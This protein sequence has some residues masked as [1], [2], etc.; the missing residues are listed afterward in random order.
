MAEIQQ[1]SGNIRY[2]H[3]DRYW[4]SIDNPDVSR[5]Y[6]NQLF[7]PHSRIELLKSSIARIVPLKKWKY[8]F[9]KTYQI[10]NSKEI[11]L[12]NIQTKNICNESQLFKMMNLD[13]LRDILE[14]QL[15]QK[16]FNFDG[17]LSFILLEDYLHSTR[18]QKLLFLFDRGSH[19]PFAVAKVSNTANNSSLLNTEFEALKSL[20]GLHSGKFTKTIPEPMVFFEHNELS[21]LIQTYLPGRSIY[22]DLRNSLFP[23]RYFSNHFGMAQ[24]WLVKFQTVTKITEFCIDEQ[25]IGE[26][27]FQPL[28]K[29]Q[30]CFDTSST[31]R[32]MISYTMHETNKLLGKRIPLVACQGD[33]WP[34]NLIIQDNTACVVDWEHYREQST[35]FTDLFM[36]ATS[37][38]LCYPWKIGSWEEPVAAFRATFLHRNWLSE[39]VMKYF[40]DYCQS[41]LISSEMLKV[42]FTVFLVERTLEE[43]VQNEKGNQKPEALIWRR[44]FSEYAKQ[45]RSVCFSL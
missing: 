20:H 4:I 13:G 30:H 45:G 23:K 12:N 22:F 42:F 10:N 18:S 21:V 27:I 36:F 33:F 7:V 6:F 35:P 37:Y 26:N 5:F 24:E 19:L 31:E 8:L 14:G 34:R 11:V 38:G 32:I 3:H 41:M 17:P 39:F 15:R 16:H 43:K 29:F 40:Q 9:Q 2:V 25:F 28:E 44:L 1:K